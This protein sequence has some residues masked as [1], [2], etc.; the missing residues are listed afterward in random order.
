MDGEIIDG[1]AV[2]VMTTFK[3]PKEQVYE[4][5]GY[6][7]YE[8]LLRISV[9]APG[10][11]MEDL[12]IIKTEGETRLVLDRKPTLV[13]KDSKTG[14]EITLN[15]QREDG[16]NAIPVGYHMVKLPTNKGW[17]PIPTNRSMWI[18]PKECLEDP[19]WKHRQKECQVVRLD[20]GML[21]L[22]LRGDHCTLPRHR[23]RR[24]QYEL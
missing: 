8:R 11:D 7:M 4:I 10:L 24:A 17:E 20:K 21:Y 13:L 16:K 23:R 22:T 3:P 2:P 5:E 12:D 15:T 18:S 1:E 9:E 19:N 14:K 6:G